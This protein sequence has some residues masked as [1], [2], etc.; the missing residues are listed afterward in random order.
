MPKKLSKQ[1]PSSSL[2]TQIFLQLSYAMQQMK[3]LYIFSVAPSNVHPGHNPQAWMQSEHLFGLAGGLS[4]RVAPQLSPDDILEVVQCC[5]ALFYLSERSP[6]L[7]C[8]VHHVY[9]ESACLGNFTLCFC[10]TSCFMFQLG[11]LNRKGR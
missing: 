7:D 5:P 2:S 1:Q 8:T 3:T 11:F 6:L 9:S 10:L 4:S